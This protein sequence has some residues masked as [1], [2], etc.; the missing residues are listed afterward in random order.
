M[1]IKVEL[2][3]DKRFAAITGGGCAETD[4]Y[5]RIDKHLD[6][7]SQLETVIHEV[8]CASLWMFDHE[9]IEVL[10]DDVIEAVDQLT[11]SRGTPE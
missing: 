1:N 2:Y 6:D 9:K 3:D 10:T 7:H 11:R 4:C 5:I 8:L